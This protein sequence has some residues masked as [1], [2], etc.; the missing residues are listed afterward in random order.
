M[1]QKK[2]REGSMEETTERERG[3]WMGIL[4]SLIFRINSLMS[5][6]LSST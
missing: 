6:L 4:K 3:E 5:S 2:V 1:W